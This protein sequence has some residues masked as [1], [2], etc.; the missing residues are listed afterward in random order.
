MSAGVCT[1]AEGT[2]KPSGSRLGKCVQG[3]E[4]ARRRHQRRLAVILTCEGQVERL[5][6]RVRVHECVRARV[7]ECVC[8]R[9]CA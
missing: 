6:A 3:S 2:G 9:V 7:P 4:K 1:R 8:M 5:R